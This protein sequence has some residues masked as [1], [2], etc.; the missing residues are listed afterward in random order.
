VRAL[1]VAPHLSSF[2]RDQVA[3]LPADVETEA[4]VLRPRWAPFD[5]VTRGRMGEG[6][7][8]G[9]PRTIHRSLFLAT[10]WWRPMLDWSRA[11]GRARRILHEGRFDLVHAHFLYPAGAVMAAAAA[12]EHVPLVIT[13]HGFDVYRLPLRGGAWRETL[14]AAMRRSAAV[15][16]V[17]RR[18]ASIL[19]GLGIPDVQV[20]PNGFDPSV[21]SPGSREEARARLGLPGDLPLLVSVGY[22][23]PI[24]GLDIVLRGVA[25]LGSP[26]RLVL[27][28]T[29]PLRRSLEA[30][31]RRLGIAERVRFA[32]EVPHLRVADYLRAADL[33]VLGS[34]D[35]GNPA[36]LVESLGCGTPVVATRVGGI[37]EVLGGEQGILV[38]P[39]DVAS[40]R[41]G[42]ERALAGTWSRDGIAASASPFAWPELARRIHAVYR[43]VLERR[44][45]A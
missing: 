42:L 45:A 4:L 41:E 34:L 37:P 26:A 39:G 24:K 31:A 13:G 10:R 33:C 35:E 36:V 18:N 44:T 40:L 19:E 6:R 28:G 16:T 12:A 14:V 1:V 2:I 5:P 29:G 3:A 32:G 17:S 11:V 9:I 30:L 25:Q 8:L 22:L 43:Q 23:V 20:I 21:F 27:V 15:I 7:E 38:R